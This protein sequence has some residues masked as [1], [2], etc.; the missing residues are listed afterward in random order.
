MRDFIPINGHVSDIG[1]AENSMALTPEAA[2]VL[3]DDKGYDS[4]VLFIPISV[5]KVSFHHAAIEIIQAVVSGNCQT[6][7]R[8]NQPGHVDMHKAG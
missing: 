3:L 4:G 8:K 6:Y 7:A 2:T 5:L 1:Q